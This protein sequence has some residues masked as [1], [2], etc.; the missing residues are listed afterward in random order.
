MIKILIVDDHPFVRRGVKQTIQED[1]GLEV[2]A[3]AEN[4][5]AALKLIEETS[6]DAVVLDLSLPGISGL[7]VLERIR[8]KHPALPVLILTMHSEEE[9]AMRVLK[10]GASGF[11]N[12]EAVPATL[13][14]AIRKIVSGGRFITPSLAEK[15]LFPAQTPNRPHETLSNRELQILKMISIGK[16]PKEIA[17]EL[18]I[19]VKTVSS[20][21]IRIME[22]MGLKNNADLVKYCIEQKLL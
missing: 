19:S 14:E 2:A 18:D 1:S 10:T 4:G 12:K 15:L 21:R 13:V 11:L 16:A 7:E 20:Y 3:E 22:K 8:E 17:A 9:Y 5:E 6:F